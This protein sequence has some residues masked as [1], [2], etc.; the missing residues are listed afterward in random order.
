MNKY[1]IAMES[2]LPFD[3]LIENLQDFSESETMYVEDVTFLGEQHL[4]NDMDSLR[5]ELNNIHE[6]KG[7][8]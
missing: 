3:V 7:Y 8:G 6:D 5:V 4:S 1:L 2:D